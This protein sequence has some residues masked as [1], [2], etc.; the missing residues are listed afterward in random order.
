MP[1]HVTN[2]VDRFACIAF[3]VEKEYGVPAVVAFAQAANESDWGRHGPKDLF[4]FGI[5]ATQDWKGGRWCGGTTE[6]DGSKYNP[7]VHC[8]R[9]YKDVNDSWRDY[10]RFLRENSHYAPAFKTNNPYDF[11][12]QVA[13][14]GYATAP[15]YYWK[16]KSLIDMLNDYVESKRGS[17][18]VFP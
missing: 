2:F 16:L 8:F 7:E 9:A 13:L 15:D 6:W 11:A 4:I 1:P 18:S 10:G 17:C 14:A 12:Y 5:K 3:Q